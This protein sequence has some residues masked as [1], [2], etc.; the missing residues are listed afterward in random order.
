VVQPYVQKTEFDVDGHPMKMNY[1][2]VLGTDDI[3]SKFGGLIGL[4]TTVVITRDGKI[5][6]RFIGLANRDQLEKQIHAAL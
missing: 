1:P 3:T 4:P 6:K 5:A 2:I